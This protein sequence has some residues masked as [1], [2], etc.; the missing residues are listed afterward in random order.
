M[1]I[2]L[3]VDRM[4]I[5]ALQFLSDGATLE[6]IDYDRTAIV[7]AANEDLEH[8][9]GVA[10]AISKKAGGTFQ[11]DGFVLVQKYGPVPICDAMAQDGDGKGYG[12]PCRYVIH[13]V[14]PVYNEKRAVDMETQL[15]GA[16]RNALNR[17]EELGLETVAFPA[18]C[19]GIFGYPKDLAAKYVREVLDEFQYKS[20]KRVVMCFFDESDM[21]AFMKHSGYQARQTIESRAK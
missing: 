13:A 19:T 14:G 3:I 21:A 7:N 8:G 5:T 4:D 17:A 1:G 12:L 2:E 6:N 11:K 16:Y 18:I 15:K 10:W 9:G 20:V